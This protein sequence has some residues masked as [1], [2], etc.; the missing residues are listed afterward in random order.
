MICSQCG[1]KHSAEE[2]ELTFRRPDVVAELSDEMRAMMVKENNDLCVVDGKR[3][4]IRGLMPLPVD[5]R[6]LPYCIGMWVEVSETAFARVYSLWDAD[7]QLSEPPFDAK[8]ANEV[9]TVGGALGLDAELHLTGPT[10]RPDVFLRKSAH[11]LYVEQTSG[12]DAHRAFEYSAL[13]A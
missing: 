8:I 6:E 12:I 5:S 1:E 4:F 10:T 9:P 7:E 3:F 2:M 11:P 13:F